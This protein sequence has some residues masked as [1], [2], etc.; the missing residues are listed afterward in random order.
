[1]D[2]TATAVDLWALAGLVLSAVAAFV[3]LLLVVDWW[4]RSL[5][6]FVVGQTGMKTGKGEDSERNQKSF[7]PK[8][9]IKIK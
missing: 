2:S 9:P 3:G 1:M 7:K 6:E 8:N 5:C 4:Q